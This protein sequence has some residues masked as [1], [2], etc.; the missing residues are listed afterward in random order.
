[1]LVQLSRAVRSSP[2]TFESEVLYPPTNPIPGRLF[3]VCGWVNEKRHRFQGLP[4]ALPNGVDVA[5]RSPHP[6]WRMLTPFPFE[7]CCLQR[8]PRLSGSTNP[9]PTAVHM[10]TFSSSVFKNSH[11][12]YHQDLRWKFLHPCLRVGCTATT[13]PSYSKLQRLQ[14]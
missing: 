11:C 4:S 1:M 2:D 10:E 7:Q 9:C 14:Q 12:Y 13:V 5:V 8:Q 3:P 6:G